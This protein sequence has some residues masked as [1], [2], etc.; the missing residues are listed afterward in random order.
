MDNINRRELPIC[1]AGVLKYGR[2]EV[3][4]EGNGEVA[5]FEIDYK[6]A[7]KGRKKLPEGW[8]IKIGKSKIIIVSLA[9]TVLS[10]TLFTY[11]GELKII[12]CSFVNWNDGVMY[13]ARIED[14]NKGEWNKNLGKW[15]SDARKPEEIE[16]FT[17]IKRKIKKSSI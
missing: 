6:G 15:G 3:T 11:I 8:M 4:F 14:L 13:N 5:C 12:N 9:E 7:I 16:N 1:T 10:E 2:G 17:I